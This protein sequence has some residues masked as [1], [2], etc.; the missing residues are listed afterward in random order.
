MQTSQRKRL[1]QFLVE[2]GFITGEQLLRAIQ[3]QRV[4]GG[5][6]G[7]CLLEMEV[8]SE[9]RLLEALS[10]QLGVPAVH[11]DQLRGIDGDVLGLVPSKL[12]VRCQAVPFAASR[13]EIHVAT[14]NVANLA[15]LDEIASTSARRVQPHIANE[16]RIFEA[17]ERYYGI[18]C[19]RR[20]GHLLDRLNRS[21]FLWTEDARKMLG[22]NELE[23]SWSDPEAVLGGDTVITAPTGRAP[24]PLRQTGPAAIT[25]RPLRSP[26]PAPPAV[27]PKPEPPAELLTLK[28]VDE[29]LSSQTEAREIAEVLLSFLSQSFTRCAVFRVRQNQA[30]GWLGRGRGIE[31]ERLAAVQLKL[32]HPSVF[33]NLEPGTA[34]YLGPLAPMPMHRELAAAWGG[35]LPRECVLV[36]VRVGERLVCVLYGDRGDKGL[37]GLRTEQLQRLAQKAAMAF[38]LCILR[39]KIQT[40]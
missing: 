25:A 27:E 8:L 7:T 30:V 5:R 11:V 39:K 10:R 22:T 13:N 17:L 1:G 21:R 40:P 2:G 19:P 14:L 37:R 18:E 32:D 34:F 4:V 33:Q 20:Y 3:S 26:A 6:I 29:L 12:A 9:E 38:E 23:I 16:V 35:E 15:F 31:A 28:R 24:Q 36:P